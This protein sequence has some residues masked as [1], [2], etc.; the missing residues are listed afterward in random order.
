MYI[1]FKYNNLI[2]HLNVYIFYINQR[3]NTRTDLN[4]PLDGGGG[5]LH[6]RSEED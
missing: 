5:D 6:V 3:P 4:A 1:I 2:N